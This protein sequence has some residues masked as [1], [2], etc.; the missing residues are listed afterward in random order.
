MMMWRMMMTLVIM[1]DDFLPDHSPSPE[2]RCQSACQKSYRSPAHRRN[3]HCLDG[4][5]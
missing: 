5:T 2:M 4:H 3:P 1:I